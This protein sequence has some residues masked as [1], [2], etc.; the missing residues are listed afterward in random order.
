MEKDWSPIAKK[1]DDFQHYITGEETDSQVKEKLSQLKELGNTI[2]F[3][4][5]T[6]HLTQVL[7]PNCDTILATDISEQMI[8]MAKTNLIK[9]DNI[10]IQQANCYSTNFTESSYDT[11]FM[12]NLI[13][14]VAK[15]EKALA[16]AYRL[17]KPNGKLIIV[18]YTTDGM[19]YINILKMIYRYLKVFGKP[20]RG[21]I[22]F[23]LNTLVDFVNT[24]QFSVDEAKLLGNKQS[25]A[26]FL[27][28][29]KSP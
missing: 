25:K 22:K 10:N 13:H 24:H 15:P 11:V 16:E 12:A 1:F 2:E 27:I 29:K 3:G 17:L 26:I 8:E 28:A 21:G 23:G 18:S 4:C 14:V 6:G 9:F 20:P 5:G 7:A 19:T